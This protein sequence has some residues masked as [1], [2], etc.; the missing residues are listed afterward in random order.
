MRP[1]TDYSISASNNHR[2]NR[3]LPVLK[4]TVPTISRSFL[5]IHI[6]KEFVKD[7]NKESL[8]LYA[9][10]E[11]IKESHEE[12]LTSWFNGSPRCTEPEPDCYGTMR[13]GCQW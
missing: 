1:D 11:K 5:R 6:G 3:P 7:F 10:F 2:I 13:P 12:E 9:F 4:Y 8:N